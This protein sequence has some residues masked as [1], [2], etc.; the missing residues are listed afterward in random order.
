MRWLFL[1][2]LLLNAALYLWQASVESFDRLGGLASAPHVRG[3]ISL[4]S[5]VGGNANRPAATSNAVDEQSEFVKGSPSGVAEGEAPQ[6]AVRESAECWALGPYGT[7]SEL[8]ALPEGLGLEW[9]VEEYRRGSDF[10]VFL[11]PYSE[12]KAAAMVFEELRGKKI[13]SF[14]IRQGVLKNAV[15]LGVFSDRTRA[16]KHIRSMRNLGYSAGVREIVK[17]AEHYWLV[18]QAYI[19]EEGYREGQEYL[20]SKLKPGRSLDKKSCNLIASYQDF[21]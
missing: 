3:N 11:G 19:N 21:D 17:Y 7:K 16:Q 15:S 14:V 6:G 8:F 1:L 12:P 18:R 9:K 5:E 13:D 20:R 2:L 10:W 4:L